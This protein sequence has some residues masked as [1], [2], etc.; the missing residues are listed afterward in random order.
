MTP[1]P[2]GKAL[3]LTGPTGSGKSQLG[4]ELA[5]LL[6]AEVVSMDSMALYR[7]LD[8]GT[9]KPGP[10]ERRRVPHHLIDVL[11]PWESASVAWWLERAAACCRDVEARG[12][13]ALFV[14]GT[15]LYLK[16][17][18]YGLFDGPPADA[19]LRGRLADEAARLGT[20]ALHRRLA[21]VDPPTAAR[22]HPND[23]RRTIRALEV[24]E[25][26]GRP[27]S[28]WQTQWG[29]ERRAEEG[30]SQP[31]RVFQLDL[32]RA[33]LY[34][35][36]DSRVRLMV[37][38][39]LVEEARALRRLGRPLSRE[40]AQAVGYKE[41]FDYLDGRCGL[42]EAVRQVQTRSRQLAR[43]Q[44]S[45]FRQLP[46][47]RPVSRELTFAL[48]GLTMEPEEGGGGRAE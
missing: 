38:A 16:A 26:T 35:R 14:G 13:R 33:E 40:A 8:V 37:E 3:V 46:P 22:L 48:L 11:E 9:A 17:L 39:G 32:P 19:Q 4:V 31:P 41:M 18:L 43:R 15:P 30:E 2:F 36:I 6:G 44:L 25:L 24:W 27:I 20:E 29:R 45:W 10:A 34:A 28:A 23:L 5:E 21:I 42:D 47:C 1:H 7:G 12:K